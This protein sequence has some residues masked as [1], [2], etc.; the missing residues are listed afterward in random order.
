MKENK[1]DNKKGRLVIDGSL[2]IYDVNNIR[3]K[4]IDFLKANDSFELDLNN[5]NE[6]DAAGVQL[7]YSARKTADSIGKQMKIHG[8]SK[9]VKESAVRLGIDPETIFI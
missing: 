6:C 3:E 7:L 5:I 9:K 1:A 2:S 4:L 8:V